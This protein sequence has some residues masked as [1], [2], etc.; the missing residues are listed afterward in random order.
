MSRIIR[1]LFFL[2]LA[3]FLFF[4][5]LWL[6]WFERG[7]KPGQEV[8]LA[9]EASPET[10]PVEQ[11]IVRDAPDTERPVEK[12]PPADVQLVASGLDT[13]WA[14]VFTAP[15]RM[16]V[17]ERPGQVRVIENGVLRDEPLSIFPEVVERGEDGAMAMTLDPEYVTNRFVYVAVA[18]GAG[19]RLVLKVVRLRDTGDRLIDP[20]AIVDGLPAARFHA[21]SRIA[22]GPDGKLYVT[23]GDATEKERAQDRSSLAG[24]VLRYNADGS[25]PADNPF[26][27]SPIWSLGHRNSQGIAWHPETGRLYATEHGPSVIDGPAGGD[28]VNL[29]ERGANY[30]WPLVSHEKRRAGTEAPLLTFTPA[31]AP[32]SL[33][34]YSGRVFPEW[35]GQLF[36]GA[37]KGEGLMRLRL[38]PDDPKKIVAYGKLREVQY[39]R[40]RDVIEG[41]DG[42]IY[43]TTSNRDGRGRPGPVDDRIFRIRP[44]E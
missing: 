27:G 23:T 17:T 12:N 4:G 11:V 26:P 24:K 5:A 18:Y 3:G 32:A 16:L 36:F 39:G 20:Q 37:L 1:S 15:D 42:F 13:P 41:P 29:I 25:I 43:F 9:P 28:E 35:K 30:G 2:L 21:G 40:I 19:D 14:I 8:R 34:I 6:G 31:E 33:M 10:A 7:V 38:D 22:F 44:K